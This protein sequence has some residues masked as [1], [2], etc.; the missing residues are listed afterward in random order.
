M[1]RFRILS[2]F[3]LAL[4]AFGCGRAGDPAAPQ[5]NA[6]AA[7]PDISA[8]EAKSIARD[9]YVYGFPLVMNLKTLYEY[10]VDADSPDYKGP[11]NEVSC[12]ARLFTPQDT[13]V[14]TPNSDTPYCMFWIDLRREPLVITV[15][16]MEAERYYSVQLIDLYT[17]NFAYIGTR[18]NSN[19]AGNYMLAGP[20]WDG[21]QPGGMTKVLESETNL[22]FA[23]IRTQLFDSNDLARVEKIQ[24]SYSMQPLST[25]Q[26]REAPPEVTVVNFPQWVAGSEFALAAFDYLDFALE[27]ID[28]HPDEVELRSKLAKIGIGTPGVFESSALEPPLATA[29]EEGL[30]QGLGD[31][32]ALLAAES[33]DPLVSAK[34]FGTRSFLER[35]AAPMGHPDYYLLRAVAARV[36]LYGNSGEEAVYPAYFV[37]SDGNPLDAAEHDYVIGFA[38]GDLP[39]VRAFWS[40]SM[41][42]GRT[43]LFIENPLDRYLLSSGMSEQFTHEQDGSIRFYIQNDS[44]GA[45]RE[46][47]WLPA[48]DGPFYL[49]LRLY[50]PEQQVLEGN[51]TPPTITKAK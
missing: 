32:R 31:M 28:T 48:P 42:D 26:S 36:G 37:D 14:V 41:Y 27:L 50:L 4:V 25:F 22:I 23:V 35:S 3:V 29:L 9:A 49:V 21:Q 18:L 10:A 45:D 6:T 39:P 17:H 19:E 24:G 11:F 7:S 51:W 47:N 38:A 2:I 43:Q 1:A 20:G 30:Q 5:T 12:E 33:A 46:A 40:L 16:K 15:P 44:P 34:I 13:T 8:E